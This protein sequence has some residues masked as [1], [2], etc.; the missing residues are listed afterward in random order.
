MN[1]ARTAEIAG[2]GLAGLTVGAALAQRGWN[3]RIHERSA[4]LREIG[5][6]IFLWE[7]ALR[8]L[9]SV[10]AID[11]VLEQGE[12]NEY[13][14]FRDERLRLLQ[15]GWMMQGARLVTVLRDVL[16]RSL[17]DAARRHGAEIVTRSRVEGATSA[18][19]L[20]LEDGSCHAADLV[21]G[22]DGV[23]SRVRDTLQLGLSVTD[24]EDGCGRHLIDRVAEDPVRRCL[25]YWM[26]GRRIG[27]V[28]CARDK[29]YIYLCCPSRDLRGRAKPLDKR[30]WIES[31]PQ[32][33]SFIERIPGEGIWASFSDV[34]THSWISGRVALVGDA[35]HAMSPNLGQGAGTAM[36]SGVALANILDRLNDV[37]GALPVWEASERPTVLATQ[38]YS[39]LYGLIGTRWPR[40]LA[41]AR[42]A[43]VW[44]IGRSAG[45][46]R[47]IN[48]AAH[49]TELLHPPVRL[50]VP[51]T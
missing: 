37:P 38:R 34:R 13:W 10:G 31:F 49:H 29:V 51:L 18:G 35:A 46:Q 3:V 50:E 15:S 19:E 22:A 4:E 45:L 43:L 25:E 21:I 12:M 6:G 30:S 23:G 32:C 33:E 41:D 26:G 48:V 8:A 24:L 27:I 1:A 9:E 40:A 47:R 28:P 16:H 11:D 7:N 36:T 17:V 39:R 5:A 20:L 42:S 14:E 2:A 44:G